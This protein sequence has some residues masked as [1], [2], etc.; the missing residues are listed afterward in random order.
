MTP[1]DRLLMVFVL[2]LSSPPMSQIFITAT[3]RFPIKRGGSRY[4]ILRVAGN[5]ISSAFSPMSA[6]GNPT[7][8]LPKAAR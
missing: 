8:V 3:A 6:S 5:G 2:T 4:L 7:S 1:F